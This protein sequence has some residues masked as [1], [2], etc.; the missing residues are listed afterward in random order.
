ME[1]AHVLLMDEC[2]LMSTLVSAREGGWR[3]KVL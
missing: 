3:Q 1:A 2:A